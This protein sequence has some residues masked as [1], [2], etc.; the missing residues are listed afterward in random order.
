MKKIKRICNSSEKK[1]KICFIFQKINLIL[2]QIKFFTRKSI[3][4][5]KIKSFSIKNK[6]KLNNN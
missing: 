5:L 4:V 6:N 2:S 1:V 3:S